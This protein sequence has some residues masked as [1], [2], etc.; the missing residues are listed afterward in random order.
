MNDEV[1][2]PFQNIKIVEEIWVDEEQLHPI[3]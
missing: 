3:S 2:Y 1:D